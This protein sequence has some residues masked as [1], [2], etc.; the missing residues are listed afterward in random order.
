MEVDADEHVAEHVA[1][2]LVEPDGD[3]VEPA[4]R[5]ADVALIHAVEDV[6]GGARH[7]LD[8]ERVDAPRGVLRVGGQRYRTVGRGVAPALAGEQ[9][10]VH[11]EERDA[12]LPVARVR[13]VGIPVEGRD[14]GERLGAGGD[15]LVRD[16]ARGD[17]RPFGEQDGAARGQRLCGGE[18]DSRE[19]QQG[20]DEEP[21][22][23][24]RGSTG[25]TFDCHRTPLEGLFS[26]E[27][28]YSVG[29]DGTRRPARW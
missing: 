25:V 23:E 2:R 27:A 24:A 6:V 20:T 18:R 22:R 12:R 28:V 29:R 1:H 17:A 7:G 11:R 19:Q 4:L 5:D 9:R 3:G 8:A 13:L 21:T 26:C 10:E 15:G 16:A 14:D